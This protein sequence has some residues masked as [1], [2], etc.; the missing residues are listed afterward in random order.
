[1]NKFFITILLGISVQLSAQ[2]GDNYHFE[3]YI[4]PAFNDM[5]GDLN[6]PLYLPES[7]PP[8]DPPVPLD[9][10]LTALLLAGGA[11][12]YRQYKKRKKA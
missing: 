5:F 11:T 8:Q 4:N 3:D 9:G 10:G 7:N 1:M 6:E 12:G 2:T